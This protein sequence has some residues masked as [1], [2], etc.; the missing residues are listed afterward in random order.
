M[1][2]FIWTA[3]NTAHIAIHGVTREEAGIRPHSPQAGLTRWRKATLNGWCE[4]EPAVAGTSRWFM[5]WIPM[6]TSTTRKSTFCKLSEKA[7]AFSVIHARP[8]EESEK[9]NLRKQRRKRQ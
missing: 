2:R 7:D 8:L 4:D 5:Y 9:R 3:W 6:R 1:A